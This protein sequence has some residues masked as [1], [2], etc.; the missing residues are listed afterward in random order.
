MYSSVTPDTLEVRRATYGS[1]DVLEQ[2]VDVT[3]IVRDLV[4][5]G[6]LSF[7]ADNDTF[8]GD[9]APGVFKR[10]EIEYRAAG[11]PIE[12]LEVFKE[13]ESVDLP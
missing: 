13:G 9:P 8:G 5:D 1:P 6:R 4:R 10:F 7:A 2:R 12:R 3:E 11:S